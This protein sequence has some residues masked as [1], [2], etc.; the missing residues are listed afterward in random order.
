[1]DHI[2]DLVIKFDTEGLDTDEEAI[3]FARL[4]V[5]TGLVNSTGTYGRFVRDVIDAFGPEAVL[6]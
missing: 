3:E 6:S 5:S 1:M 4:L 2:L